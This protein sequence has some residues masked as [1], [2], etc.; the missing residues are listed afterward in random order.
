M[1]SIYIFGIYSQIVVCQSFSIWNIFL[2]IIED[3]VMYLLVSRQMI[4]SIDIFG[5]Y[6]Q[7]VV[8]QRVSL[9]NIF[10]CIIGDEQERLLM[11]FS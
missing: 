11:M 9:W 2:C 7:I 1:S 8:C 3:I 6:S 10:L 4:R 5:I